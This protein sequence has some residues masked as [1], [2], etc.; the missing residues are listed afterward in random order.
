[1]PGGVHYNRLYNN[2]NITSLW[3]AWII[4]IINMSMYCKETYSN[5]HFLSMI[6]YSRELLFWQTINLNLCVYRRCFLIIRLHNSF[7]TGYIDNYIISYSNLIPS[8]LLDTKKWHV[9]NLYIHWIR[10]S[11]NQ[12]IIKDPF[13]AMHFQICM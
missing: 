13:R 8:M 7:K 1:M 10:P 3:K 4:K 6:F 2:F 11:I 12:F 5:K 9:V